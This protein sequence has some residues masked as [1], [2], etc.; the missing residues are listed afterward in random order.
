[1]K[2]NRKISVVRVYDSTSYDY[3]FPSE[4]LDSVVSQDS[5][6]Y[7]PISFLSSLVLP[8]TPDCFCSSIYQR[9]QWQY[10]ARWNPRVPW[11]YKLYTAGV[12]FLHKLRL[13]V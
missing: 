9:F 5:A 6:L 1:M 8:I 12:H 10:K 2:L 11:E 4:R 13:R 7:F 3:T